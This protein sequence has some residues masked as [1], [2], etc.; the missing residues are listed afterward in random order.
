MLSL[1]EA[2]PEWIFLSLIQNSSLKE[3]LQNCQV[4]VFLKTGE[5]G[6]VAHDFSP[7]TQ[8]VKVGESQWV[9]GQPRLCVA[10]EL[11]DKQDYIVRPNLK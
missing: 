3:I 7:S 5:W 6:T 11:Q 4:F 10:R 1:G 2:K 9:Q 8:G